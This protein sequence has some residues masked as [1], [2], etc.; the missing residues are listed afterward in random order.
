MLLM[1]DLDSRVC[2]GGVMTCFSSGNKIYKVAGKGR[3]VPV[4]TDS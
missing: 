3:Q 4:R 1:P 2:V